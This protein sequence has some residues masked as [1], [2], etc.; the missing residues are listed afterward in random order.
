MLVSYMQSIMIA[1]TNT[2]K[3]TP[4]LNYFPYLQNPIKIQHISK[5]YKYFFK[6]VEILYKYF[7]HCTN[8]TVC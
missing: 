1:T 4:T 3:P 5:L 2:Q 8:C 7:T 6:N